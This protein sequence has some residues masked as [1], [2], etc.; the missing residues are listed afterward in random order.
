MAWVF[1]DLALPEFRQR[2]PSA[3]DFRLTSGG[4]T[5]ASGGRRPR[6]DAFN[7][8]LGSGGRPDRWRGAALGKAASAC[9][10]SRCL[11]GFGLDEGWDPTCGRAVEC[12]RVARRDHGPPG[13]RSLPAL[14]RQSPEHFG[15]WSGDAGCPPAVGQD[16]SLPRG[17]PIG[18][19]EFR[20]AGAAAP[21]RRCARLSKIPAPDP[22]SPAPDSAARAALRGARAHRSTAGGWPARRRPPR[23]Q[24]RAY[25]RRHRVRSG[26]RG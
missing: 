24:R 26:R 9:I 4:A 8:A 21:Q 3:G 23:S 2:N 13:G 15:H 5:V 17:G 22:A 1:T 25:A 19:A 18:R 20:P 6:Y 14:P 10:R 7:G 16:F 12:D 11:M